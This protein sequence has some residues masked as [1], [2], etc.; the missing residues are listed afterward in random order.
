M[1]TDVKTRRVIFLIITVILS[2]LFFTTPSTLAPSAFNIG[3]QSYYALL[4]EGFL[5]GQLSLPI[6]PSEHLLALPDPYDP[7]ENYGLTLHDASLYHNKYYLYFGPLPA[8]A[9]FI[10][11]KLLTRY[12]PSEALSVVFFLSLGFIINFIL[13]IQI[14]KRYFP[15]LPEAQ[16]LF[17]GLLLAYA[18][19]APFLLTRGLFYELAIA[20]AYCA[21]SFAL[22][23]L[24]K[25][26]TNNFSKVQDVV[27]FSLFLALSVSGRANFSLICIILIPAILIYMI[28]NAPPKKL[29]VL[30]V[31][32]LLPAIIIAIGLAIYNYLRFN[33]IFEF[34]EKYALSGVEVSK[35]PPMF[36]TNFA[37]IR[38]AIYYYFFQTFTFGHGYRHFPNLPHIYIKPNLLPPQ[39]PYYYEPV[40]G[41]F[42][43]TP[44]AIFI[45]ALPAMIKSYLKNGI[46]KNNLLPIFLIF[47]SLVPTIIM[48]F[49]F[50]LGW[51]SNQRYEMDFSP[52]LTLLSIVSYW[53]LQKS[54]LKHW[55]LNTSKIIFIILAALSILIGLDIGITG[56]GI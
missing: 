45:F 29:R 9:F 56:Y 3:G 53:L 11:F 18:T 33:S 50:L 12:Y 38:H 25:A 34:G 31:S 48:L 20:S 6:L 42:M 35:M 1:N 46:L 2:Y 52:Y 10:P 23:F 19:T 44:I 37:M 24:Y 32:I 22:F 16:V 49:Y 14:K 21:T 40:A 43:L 5:S 41:Y 28:K 39:Q 54:E 47:T 7:I 55:V 30:I 26:V 36:D 27:F 13:L 15:E 4:S 17:A 8:L 51:S